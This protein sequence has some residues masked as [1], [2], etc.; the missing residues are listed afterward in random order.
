MNREQDMLLF[1]EWK[2]NDFYDVPQWN[3][4]ELKVNEFKIERW[5]RLDERTTFNFALKF[6]T[7]KFIR[8]E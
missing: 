7:I 1:S 3:I 2:Y 5:K 8:I 6:E 4:L